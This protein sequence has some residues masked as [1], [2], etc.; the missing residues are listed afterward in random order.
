VK[1]YIAGIEYDEDRFS[2]GGD[3]T[4]PWTVLPDDREYV[5]PFIA[6]EVLEDDFVVVSNHDQ[7]GRVEDVLLGARMNLQLGYASTAFGSLDDAVL[8]TAGASKGLGNP[9]ANSLLSSADFSMRWQ[10]EEA[11]NLLLHGSTALY[12]RHS[13]RRLLFTSL[14]ANIGSNLDLDNPLYLGGDNGLRGYPLRYQGG[15]S[16]VLFTLEQRYFTDWYPFQLFRVGGAVFFDAGRTWGDNPVGAANLGWL[17]DVGFGLRIGNNRAGTGKVIHVDL[18]F[19][20][21]G[22]DSIDSVQFLVEARATF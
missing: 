1:R 19:P 14:D 3:P 15:D 22:E 2:P 4:L 9:G 6:V 7:I 21:D 16:S 8:L 17:R 18:A 20:L 5:Y 12:L 11:Q 13:P 10:D